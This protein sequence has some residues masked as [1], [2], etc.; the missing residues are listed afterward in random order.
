[1]QFVGGYA[2]YEA[3]LQDARAYDDV[4]I[5]LDGVEDAKTVA[6]L[7]ARLRAARNGE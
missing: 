2:S 4:R 3:L 1:M 5:A 7:E 6:A